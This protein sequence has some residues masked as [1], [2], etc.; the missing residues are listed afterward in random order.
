LKSQPIVENAIVDVWKKAID[1]GQANLEA[2]NASI[3]EIEGGW[4]LS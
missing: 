2:A 3:Q 4:N 1:N